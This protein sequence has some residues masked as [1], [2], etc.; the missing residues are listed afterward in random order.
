MNE[1]KFRVTVGDVCVAHLSLFDQ[2]SIHVCVPL[3]V[4]KVAGYVFMQ[5]LGS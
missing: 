2:L 4:Y 3:L 1:Y 5:K